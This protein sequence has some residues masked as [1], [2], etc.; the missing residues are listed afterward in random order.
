MKPLKKRGRQDLD[1][2]RRRQSMPQPSSNIPSQREEE[3]TARLCR[4]LSRTISMQRNCKQSMHFAKHWSWKSYCP[5]NMMITIWCWGYFLGLNDYNPSFYI[6]ELLIN[7]PFN[8]VNRFLK[9]RKFD[10]EKTKQMWSDM[11]QWRKEV[12]ADTIIEVF[13]CCSM[14]E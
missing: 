4:L 14:I 8:N 6:T 9:A 1:L 2:L 13:L 11:L 5:Q 7:L 10:I 3:G 12:G